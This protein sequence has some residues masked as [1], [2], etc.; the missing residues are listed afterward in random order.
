MQ[1][2]ACPARRPAEPQ[3]APPQDEYGIYHT[4]GWPWG[5]TDYAG[6]AWVFPPRPDGVA[7]TRL[8]D[9]TAHTILVG[10]KAME[11]KNYLT[12]TWFWDEPF[13]TGGAGGTARDGD[14]ILRDGPGI[15]F[16]YNWGSAHAPG[17]QFLFG[18][19]SVRLVRHGTAPVA[20]RALLTPNGGEV[21]PNPE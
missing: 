9:G 3:K 7:L 10:E 20:V 12:G 5:K 19:G 15:R 14:L 4:G 17:P 18:D 6:N 21:S 2:Y 1:L 13:F 16:P 11:P 8:T